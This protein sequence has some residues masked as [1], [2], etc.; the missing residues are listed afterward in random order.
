MNSTSGDLAAINRI[1]E[2]LQAAENDGDADVA[3]SHMTDDVVLMVPDFP[4]Q[5]G[6]AAATAFMRD[7]MRVLMEEFDRHISY[8]S[9]EVV[10]MG[11]VAFDRG[12]F[13]FTTAPRS[14][15]PERQVTGKYLW[16]LRRVGS[17]SWKV[18]RLIVCRDDGD[19]DETGENATVAA[20]SC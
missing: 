4:I 5:E 11:E 7:I 14:G 13:A 2:A 6:K 9:G 10:V 12:T 18:S 8:V 19:E 15:G 17:E 3:A 16:L 20:Q 1:R